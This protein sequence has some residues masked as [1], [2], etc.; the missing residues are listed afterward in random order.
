MWFVIICSICI[1]YVFVFRLIM[2]I[3]NEI[4]LYVCLI[5]G[6]KGEYLLN[7]YCLL[8]NIK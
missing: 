4:C 5:I 2:F 3:C 7:E 8:L 1:I 6:N